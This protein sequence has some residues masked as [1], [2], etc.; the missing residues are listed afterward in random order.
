MPLG[1]LLVAG[2]SYIWYRERRSRKQLEQRLSEMQSSGVAALEGGTTGHNNLGG[3]QVVQELED[4]QRDPEL[5]S[6]PLVEVA[7]NL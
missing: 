5:H 2:F 4:L 1:A 3:S 7:N 6:Q